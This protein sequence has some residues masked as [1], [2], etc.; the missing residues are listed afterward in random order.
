MRRES[1]AI[2]AEIEKM[3]ESLRNLIWE[4]LKRGF[5]KAYQCCM[6]EPKDFHLSMM[7]GYWRDLTLISETQVF[8]VVDPVQLQ[9]CENAVKGGGPA[10]AGVWRG[11]VTFKSVYHHKT[12]AERND[13]MS[14]ES[15]DA[16]YNATLVIDGRKDEN[17]APVGKVKATASQT[18]ER[19]GRGSGECY[20]VSRQFQTVSGNTETE[21]IGFTISMN[22]RSGRYNIS[23]AWPGVVGNGSSSV[24]S[25][26]KG[27]CRNPYNK[28]LHQESPIKDG[29]IDI[30]G[31]LEAEGV[32]DPEEDSVLSGSKNATIPLPKGG[33][34]QVTMTWSLSRCKAR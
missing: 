24:T 31:D 7:I 1:K 14:Y 30:Y 34:A 26:V 25:E 18:K 9:Q 6:C 2:A 22:P 23:V 17:G 29:D 3:Y 33:E 28:D 10:A 8:D 19:G 21:T 4:T 13:N 27:V 16:L 32:I 11:T 20:R 15:E 5:N 12:S